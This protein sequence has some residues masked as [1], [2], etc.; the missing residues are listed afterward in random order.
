MAKSRTKTAA[1]RPRCG[2]CGKTRK[3]NG[4]RAMRVLVDTNVFAS[5][6]FWGGYPSRVL[7]L[8]ARDRFELVLS[9]DIPAEYA[10]VLTDL[11]GREAQS[12]L[13][14][15]WLSLLGHHTVPVNVCISVRE[16]R[17][18][19]D[20]KYLA[21][22]VDGSADYIVSGDRDL[23]AVGEFRGVPIVTRRRFVEQMA[24]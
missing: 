24:G 17:D 3:L 12:E 7:E 15:R 1:N 4:R 13:A 11:G 23:P 21:C 9:L 18:P 16:C 2:L 19:H 5:G 20:E 8:W 22:A 6:I 10:R 14:K